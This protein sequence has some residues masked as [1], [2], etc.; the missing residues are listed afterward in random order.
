LNRRDA[1]DAEGRREEY[2]EGTEVGAIALLMVTVFVAVAL[3]YWGDGWRLPL[4]RE[5]LTAGA[6]LVA[7]GVAINIA[8]IFAQWIVAFAIAATA[9]TGFAIY[10]GRKRRA[11]CTTQ[12]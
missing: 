11:E 1:K 8:I 12:T 5:S 9:I 6:T 10:A 2:K 4:V 3:V 7:V